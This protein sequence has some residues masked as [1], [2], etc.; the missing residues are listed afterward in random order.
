LLDGLPNELV[1]ARN[2]Q[3]CVTRVKSS[4]VSGFVR[5]QRFYTRDEAAAML[6]SA[7]GFDQ[8]R[9]LCT[10]LQKAA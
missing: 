2:A 7:S 6:V 1:V 4:V 10:S 9:S 5:D 8:S 3:G